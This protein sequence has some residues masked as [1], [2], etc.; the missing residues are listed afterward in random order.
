MNQRRWL[1][2]RALAWSQVLFW[3]AWWA[4]YLW[5][6]E[7]VLRGGSIASHLPLDHLEPGVRVLGVIAWNLLWMLLFPA[8]ANL[9]QV[10]QW[11]LGLTA[12]LSLW[13][14]YGL[15]LGTNSFAVPLPT[16][17]LPSLLLLLERAGFLEL[18]AY[19]IMALATAPSARWRQ[20]GWFAGGLD[21]LTPSALTRSDWL[22]LAG[23]TLLLIA[24]AGREV[25]Q[26]CSATAGC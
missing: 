6:P 20:N 22:A 3:T 17:P 21:R 26:W 23:A 19:L 15:L 12:V 10:R 18:T 24:A 13:A 7:G 9:V 16:R 14:L 2:V 11:P 25:L 4:G 8:G 1:G 5:L